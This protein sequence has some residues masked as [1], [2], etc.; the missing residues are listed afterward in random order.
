MIVSKSSGPIRLGLAVGLC[1]AVFIGNLCEAQD[2]QIPGVAPV[3]TDEALSPPSSIPPVSLAPGATAQIPKSTV[4]QTSIKTLGGSATPLPSGSLSQIEINVE[5]LKQLDPESLGTLAI[6]EGGFGA[7]MWDGSSRRNIERLLSKLPTRSTSRAMRDLMR[8]LLLSSAKAP[9]GGPLVSGKKDLIGTRLELLSAM[10]DLSGVSSLIKEV[11]ATAH[12]DRLLRSEVDA[13]FMRNDN[14]GVCSL[15][16]SQIGY[17]ETPYWQKAFIFCQSL[18][19]EHE[20]AALGASLLRETGDNDQIFNGLLEHL[21]GLGVYKVA[22]LANP[23]PLHFAMVRAAKADLPSDVTSSN[24][25]AILRTIATSPNARPELRLDAAERAEAMGALRTDV[26]RQLYAGVTFSEKALEN[27]LTTADAQRSPLSRALLYR[28]ALVEN[29]PAATAEVLSKALKLARDGG[30]LPSLARVYLPILQ[31]IIPT[32]DF[33]WFSPEVIRA[34]LAAG[35]LKSASQWF[36]MLKNAALLDSNAAKIL[37]EIQP[38]ARLA[39]AIDDTD[40]NGAGLAKWWQ[41]SNSQKEEGAVSPEV[42]QTRAAL[43]FNLLDS[44]G[45]EVGDEEWGLLLDG[46]AQSTAVMPRPAF[47]RSLEIAAQNLRIGETILLSLLALGES[48]PAQASPTVLHKV[49]KSLRII[50]LE[51]EARSLALEAA[52]ASGL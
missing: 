38:L 30:R 10:G 32:Q 6:E 44:F 19:G 16:A 3:E 29:V 5:E 18:A 47:W 35:D 1:A 17:V 52:V 25:P 48:G 8:R 43:L 7:L 39:G 22:S 28:K 34:L 36:I 14:A 31:T 45:D 50:G 23:E 13:L 49:I 15:V 12:T 40:W 4:S 42:I 9:I 20:K 21:S 33:V 41:I 27:P 51:Q 24:N 26:L 11:P 37:G 46:P 2:G